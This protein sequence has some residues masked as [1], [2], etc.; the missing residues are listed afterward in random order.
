M[1]TSDDTNL[2]ECS[3]Q[4]VHVRRLS[5]KQQ[6]QTQQSQFQPEVIKS[7]L[8]LSSARLALLTSEDP[9]QALYTTNG[10]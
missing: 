3:I 7:C 5:I 10:R 9:A 2:A 4:D 6:Q 8:L 1:L